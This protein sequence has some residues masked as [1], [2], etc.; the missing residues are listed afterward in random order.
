MTVNTVSIPAVS[1]GFIETVDFMHNGVTIPDT[2]NPGRYLLAG[3]LGYCIKDTSK[4][5]AG[6]TTD[7]N[8]FYDSIAKA[9]TIALLKE[10]LGQTRLQMEQTLM[11]TLGIAQQQMCSLNY[12]VGTIS[13]LNSFY[14]GKNLGFSFCSG[15][16]ALPQ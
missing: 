15:A 4:C 7:F 11:Q 5:Q 10:P 9:F 12:Y 13:D 8:I 14:A 3:N 2:A 16:T 6:N 1:G